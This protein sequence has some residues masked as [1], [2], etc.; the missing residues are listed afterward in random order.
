MGNLDPISVMR[1]GTPELVYEKAME[2]LRDGAEGGGML[3]SSAGGMAPHTPA[4]N[5]RA[6]LRATEDYACK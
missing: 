2:C 4:E 3:L 1:D 6:A 5:V